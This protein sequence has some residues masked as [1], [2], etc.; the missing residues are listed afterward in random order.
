MELFALA[1]ARLEE[2]PDSD[3]AGVL[4]DFKVRALRAL[5]EAARE[6]GRVEEAQLYEQ[7]LGEAGAS[8]T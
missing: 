2:S 6:A 5:A 7:A 1:S 8:A 4:R 3:D